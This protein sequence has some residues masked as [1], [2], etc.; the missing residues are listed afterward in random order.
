MRKS[1]RTPERFMSLTAITGMT[2]VSSSCFRTA[3]V[4]M[5]ESFNLPRSFMSATTKQSVRFST[6]L[7]L[8]RMSCVFCLRPRRGSFAASALKL[9]GKIST[10]VVKIPLSRRSASLN[11]SITFWRYDWEPEAI[12][13]S[14]RPS[15]R[16]RY[17]RCLRL[18]PSVSASSLRVWKRRSADFDRNLFF[19]A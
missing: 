9:G 10:T 18:R 11:H 15:S 4:Y 13:A 8:E 6:F 7:T 14:A 16:V 12:D 1:V 5:L 17:E 3:A 19:A 2:S